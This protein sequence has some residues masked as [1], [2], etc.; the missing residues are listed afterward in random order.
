MTLFHLSASEEW[1]PKT[2]GD[3]SNQMPSVMFTHSCHALKVTA[4]NMANIATTGPTMAGF[5][6]ASPLTSFCA[7]TNHKR[8]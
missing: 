2:H 6:I 7:E 1:N 8:Y 5:H 4:A 3:I